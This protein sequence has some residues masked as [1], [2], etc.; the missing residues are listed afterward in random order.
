MASTATC[1]PCHKRPLGRQY[2]PLFPQISRPLVIVLLWLFSLLFRPWPNKLARRCAGG[3]FPR[4]S[5][6]HARWPRGQSANKARLCARL[7][8]GFYVARAWR[9]NQ[10]SEDQYL[11]HPEC[12]RHQRHEKNL[13]RLSDGCDAGRLRL[14]CAALDCSGTPRAESGATNPQEVPECVQVV[15]ACATVAGS[16]GQAT[17]GRSQHVKQ[18]KDGEQASKM[19]NH[20]S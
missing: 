6:M 2:P 5:Q 15:S 11:T 8:R 4:E 17:V 7:V 10:H 3:K 14:G 13:T 12:R 16:C 1:A 18:A 19:S 9:C 20:E